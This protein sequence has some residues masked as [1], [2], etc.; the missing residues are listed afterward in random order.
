LLKGVL[1][2]NV[3]YW[4]KKPLTR[5]LIETIVMKWNLDEKGD[6]I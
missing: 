6:K 2:E 5:K 3:G 1:S 4:M